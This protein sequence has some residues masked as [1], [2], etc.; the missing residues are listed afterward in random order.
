MA[1]TMRERLSEK[2]GS[3]KTMFE[4]LH[5]KKYEVR[6]ISRCSFAYWALQGALTSSDAIPWV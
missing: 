6:I 3:R 1:Q 5:N 2:N 4:V